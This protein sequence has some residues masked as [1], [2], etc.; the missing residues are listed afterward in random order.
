LLDNFEWV[1]G[2]GP[3]FGLVNVDFASQQRI[4]KDSGKWFSEFLKQ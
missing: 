4:I 3:K 1:E 2:Y